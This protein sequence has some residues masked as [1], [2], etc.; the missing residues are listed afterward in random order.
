MDND[1]D[2][3]GALGVLFDVV[4]EGNRRLDAGEDAASLTAAYD[5]S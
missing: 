3:A 1:F 5:S 4:R 2:I